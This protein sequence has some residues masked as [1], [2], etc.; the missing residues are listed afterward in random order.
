MI[1]RRLHHASPGR[2]CRGF[3]RAQLLHASH[4]PAGYASSIYLLSSFVGDQNDV[5]R[6]KNGKKVHAQLRHWRICMT[7]RHDFFCENCEPS[8]AFDTEEG[9]T[10]LHLPAFLFPTMEHNIASL[11]PDIFSLQH[12]LQRLSG[13]NP[14]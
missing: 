10:N 1:A 5:Q 7:P 9:V 8:K 2:L 6:K 12:Y 11:Q 4:R 13:R 3:S 14:L